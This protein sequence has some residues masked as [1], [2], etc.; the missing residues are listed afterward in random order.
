MEKIHIYLYLSVTFCPIF[1]RKN[2]S[3]KISA[4]L[5]KINTTMEF[6]TNKISKVQ[7]CLF[8]VRKKNI[9]S[10]YS[11]ERVLKFRWFYNLER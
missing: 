2:F 5:F 8:V 10:S 7:V 1:L 6:K 3:L 11:C 9:K 4:V